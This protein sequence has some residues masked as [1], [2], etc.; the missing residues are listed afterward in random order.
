MTKI[1]IS[2]RDALCLFGLVFVFATY[3]VLCQNSVYVSVRVVDEDGKAIAKAKASLQ[4]APCDTCIDHAF[5]VYETSQNGYFVLSLTLDRRGDIR[6]FVEDDVPEGFW[7]PIFPIH[8]K[9]SKISRFRGTK[10]KLTESGNVRIGDV[11]ATVKYKKISIDLLKLTDNEQ[12]A[13]D[14]FAKTA[15]LTIKYGKLEIADHVG[16]H[17]KA[18][19]EGF[20]NLAL[21]DGEWDLIFSF[22]VN[23]QER[24]V[25]L[26]R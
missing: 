18:Y 16:I 21:P 24:K 13:K 14:E 17:P 9:L 1:M 22:S 3:E 6:L 7:N 10:L 2:V 11:R 8:L 23:S 26:R 4:L 20:I 12:S 25:T 15:R 19:K 5:P